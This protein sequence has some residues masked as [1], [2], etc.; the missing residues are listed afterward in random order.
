MRILYVTTVAPPAGMVPC[1]SIP[2]FSTPKCTNTCTDSKYG[3]RYNTDKHLAR[4]SYSVRGEAN[5]Q[6]ELMEKGTITVAFVVYEDFELYS[7][8]VYKYVKGTYIL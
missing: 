8:G 5:M 4:T 7:S 6:K 2:M 1:D 3:T